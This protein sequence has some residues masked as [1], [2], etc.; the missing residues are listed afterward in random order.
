MILHFSVS[1]E[2]NKKDCCYYSVKR[3]WADK[4]VLLYWCAASVECRESHL[5]RLSC[6]HRL[7]LERYC[8]ICRWSYERGARTWCQS[9]IVSFLLGCLL[10]FCSFGW[11]LQSRWLIDTEPG[12][13][14]DGWL[15]VCNQPSRS[16]QPSTL[17]GTVKWVSALGLSNN[18]WWWWM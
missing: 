4:R 15:L 18:K 17:H 3:Y 11:R 9:S 2:V 12:Y 6:R 16:T 5:P 8:C 10:L 1:Q 7:S 14:L 13:C